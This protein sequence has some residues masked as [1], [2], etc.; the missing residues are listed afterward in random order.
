MVN[1]ILRK[2]FVDSIEYLRKM[3]FFKDYS[4][5]SSEEILERIFNGEINYAY[6]W[7]KEWR[8]SILHSQEG[9]SSFYTPLEGVLLKESLEEY[10][11]D[12]MKSSDA[13]IDCNIISF[14]TKRAIEEKSETVVDDNL[15]VT[16]LKR[17]ARISRGIFQPTNISW[18]WLTPD[19]SK[20]SIQE[21]SFDFKGSRHAIQIVLKHDYIEDMGL[22]E[23]NELIEDTGYKYYQV[24][25]KDIM[26]IIVVVLTKEE[27]EKLRKERGWEFEYIV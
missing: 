12:W 14:D 19:E 2:R 20:W 24:E 15:G 4:D 26:R 27:A 16:M 8:E 3:D 22:A 18:R 5:L 13:E 10:E 11:D 6:S 25:C 17:L 1:P 21:V 7:W 9:K 23:L